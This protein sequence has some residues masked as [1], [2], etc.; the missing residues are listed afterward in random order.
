[1]LGNIKVKDF[2][3]SFRI[4]DKCLRTFLIQGKKARPGSL[5]IN[6]RAVSEHIHP[7]KPNTGTIAYKCI[8]IKYIQKKALDEE[9]VAVHS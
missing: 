6:T 8:H 7:P 4:F 1:M 5:N 2:H 9:L 3:T